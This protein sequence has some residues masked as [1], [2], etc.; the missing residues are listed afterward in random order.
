[1]SE[2]TPTVEPPRPE[3]LQKVERREWVRYPSR[4]EVTCRLFGTPDDHSWPAELR[5]VSA[6]GCGLV[7]GCSFVRGSI[8]EVRP[9]NQT[10]DFGRKLLVRVKNATLLPCGI[11]QLGCTFVRELGEAEMQKLL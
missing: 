6:I 2:I 1:M 9:V 5:D 8:L 10:W 7:T 11:W 4:L 3:N